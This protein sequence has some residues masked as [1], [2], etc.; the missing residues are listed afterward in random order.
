MRIATEANLDKAT[1]L[2]HLIHVKVCM[3]MQV[4]HPG[5]QASFC[6]YLQEAAAASA[7]VV[8]LD[9]D[10]NPKRFPTHVIEAM[11]TGEPSQLETLFS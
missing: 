7:V 2:G 3:D 4:N 9:A 5:R 8:S 11:R 1:A 6:G 10:Y